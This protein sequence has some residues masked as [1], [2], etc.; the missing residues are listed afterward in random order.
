MG[1]RGVT[2]VGGLL[3]AALV[4][5]CGERTSPKGATWISL[6]AGNAVTCGVTASG[7]GFCWGS[8]QSGQLGD[9]STTQRLTPAPVAGGLTFA[10]LTAGDRH[11]C[12]VTSSGVAYCWGDDSVGELGDSTGGAPASNRPTPVAVAG[13]LSFVNLT[14]GGGHTCGVTGAGVAYCWGYDSYGQLGDSSLYS[15]AH[16]TPVAV[17]GGLTFT[18]L[19]AGFMHTCGVTNNGATYCWGLAEVGALGDGQSHLICYGF[20][21]FPDAPCSKSP[22][23]V[24]G[25]LTFASVTAGF[26]HTCGL[27]R[28]GAAYCWGDNGNGQLGDGS[29][30]RQPT[31]V[32]V[33]GG[34]T[35]ASLTAGQLQTCGLTGG[36]AA[37]CWGDNTYGELGDGSTTRRLT[38]VAVT[39]GL[40]F[41]SLRAGWTHACG[42]TSGGAAY[43]WGDN[44]Y[45][46]LGDGTTTQR[47]VPV[48]VTTP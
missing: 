33:A 9:S 35:F 47:L 23:A 32:A 8:N 31:P 6:A 20:K 44:T 4:T 25:G 24:A 26:G 13:G 16:H 45:G 11:T 14:A 40:T 21:A 41:A 38:P 34:L 3:C 22:V 46:E 1:P 48:A 15:A 2:V 29:T 42:L 27:T 12:V 19:T 10:S 30:T 39:G 37:Y 43:C 18:N 36:G 5:A 7:A 28:G 17:V